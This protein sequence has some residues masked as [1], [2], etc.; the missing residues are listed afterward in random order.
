M[1]Y[2][3][4]IY[5]AIEHVAKKETDW[6]SAESIQGDVEET[7]G[8]TVS[9]KKIGWYLA[10]IAKLNHFHTRKGRGKANEYLPRTLIFG[11]G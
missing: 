11:R 6:L 2:A 8:E 1:V 10:T 3:N 5:K 9:T 4:V 7:V